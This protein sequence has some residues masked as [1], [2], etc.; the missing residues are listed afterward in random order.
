VIA[1]VTYTDGDGARLVA[2]LGDDV[3]WTA[4]DPEMASA[5]NALIRAEDRSAARGDWAA[6]HAEKMARR[7]GASIEIEP[8]DPLPEG[9]VY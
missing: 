4:D 6:W 9:T 8:K 7:L 5:L 1:R 2:T 3:T